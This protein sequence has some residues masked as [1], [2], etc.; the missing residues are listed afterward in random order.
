MTKFQTVEAFLESLSA[1]K[2]R[3]VELLRTII[4]EAHDDLI[5]II[6]WNALS[7]VLD[8]EDRLTFNVVNKQ[9]TV[10][11]V[12]HMGA[13]RKEDKKASPIMIDETGMI[14][15]SSDIRGML[16]FEN[17]EVISSKR[18]EITRLIARWLDTR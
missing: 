6:K 17:Y 9:G 12:L 11:L 1:E 7:Y 13:I 2:L 8:G 16:S 14:V 5:E 10:K 4:L 15:W 18:E 3:Q